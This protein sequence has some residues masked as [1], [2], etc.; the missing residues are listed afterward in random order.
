MAPASALRAARCSACSLSA[1][2]LFIGNMAEAHARTTVAAIESSRRLA[3]SPASTFST[4]RPTVRLLGSPAIEEGLNDQRNNGEKT[5]EASPETDALD[6]PWYLQVEAPRHPTLLH[7]PPPLPNIPE[8]SPKLMEPL[9]QFVADEL[10]LDDLSLLDLREM[11]PPPALGPDLIML[12]GTAR[13][14]RHL[15]VSADRLVR[16]L[17]GRGVT[18]SA[19]GLLGRNELKIK[20]RRIAR[21]AKL[22]G[23]SGVP[24]GGDDGISTGWICV[25]LGLVGGSTQEMVMVDEQGRPTGFG[26]PQTGTTIV[27]QMLTETRRKE[28]DLESLWSGM[29]QRSLEKAESMKQIRGPSSTG[30]GRQPDGR[31]FFSTSS[32]RLLDVEPTSES[33]LADAVL[34]SAGDL[35]ANTLASH[36]LQ[37]DIK[38]KLHVLNQ[39]KGHFKDLP[40]AEADTALA[41]V[42]DIQPS[43][44]LR[45][46]ERT[47]ENLPP[48]QAWEHRMWL[49]NTARSRDLPGYDLSVAKEWLREIQF[50]GVN[51]TRGICLDLIQSIYAIPATNDA[52][53]R[54]QSALA[55]QII[56]TM[57]TRGQ[58]VLDHDVIVT[59]IE[60]LVR[61]PSSAPEA[62]RLLAQFETL[63]THADLPCPSED[64]L[65]RLM[66]AYASQGRWE[67]VWEVWRIPPRHRQARSSRLYAHIYHIF[68]KDGHRMRCI[69]ALRRTYYEMAVEE[70]PVVVNDSIRRGL[71]ECIRI[72]DPG[73][74]E[75]AKT[76]AMAP[77]KSKIAADR[78]FVAMMIKSQIF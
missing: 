14:E 24:R 37:H 38:A 45:L 3:P 25:N 30:R 35:D 40:D 61:N 42:Q 57:Y 64:L 66:H 54:D 76:V 63:L 65:V 6:T 46:F 19:D 58:K 60:A 56:D 53:V 12:F 55:M 68:A 23:S 62:A 43:V 59:V 1:L 20:L 33:F 8:G 49:W 16:W 21:K 13:S 51:L 29:L 70:P 32:R 41:K 4:F 39:L 2:R 73:A 10:G 36:I 9:V 78:E 71:R 27:V 52:A 72:A 67:R 48:T 11:D 22:L 7:E 77:G 28:L 15:H 5:A 44:F 75:I 18:A 17:R 74:E 50:S 31:R 69:E 34:G 47:L 26:V